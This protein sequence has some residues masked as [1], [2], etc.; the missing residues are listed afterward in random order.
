MEAERK[1][2]EKGGWA[3]ASGQE[4]VSHGVTE[5]AG[6]VRTERS[7]FDLAIRE[8]LGGS[9]VEASG[10]QWRQRPETEG[11]GVPGGWRCWYPVNLSFKEMAAKGRRAGLGRRARRGDF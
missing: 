10:E 8:H 4:G 1:C 5:K 3:G 6:N 2:L 9:A 11:R 7:A